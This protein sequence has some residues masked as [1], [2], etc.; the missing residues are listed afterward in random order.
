MLSHGA[1]AKITA[2]RSKA[3][4]MDPRMELINFEISNYAF[5][6]FFFLDWNIN[7]C[8]DSQQIEFQENSIGACIANIVD[9]VSVLF[10]S[11]ADPK[12]A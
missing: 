2:V 5:E 3:G 11:M 1:I 4:G 8:A 6:I 9:A 12:I 7:L 10:V